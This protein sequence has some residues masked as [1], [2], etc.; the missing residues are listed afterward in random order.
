MPLTTRGHLLCAAAVSLIFLACRS[1]QPGPG[2]QSPVLVRVDG[3]DVTVGEAQA[4]L[5]H[6]PPRLRATYASTSEKQREFMQRL[7]DAELLANKAKALGYD[8][9][10]E[11]IASTK[12][13]MVRRFL[14]ARD[15]ASQ[16]GSEVSPLTVEAFYRDNQAM[17][18]APE[19]ARVT[20]VIVSDGERA[21]EVWRLATASADRHRGD[22]AADIAAFKELV[23]KYSVD[24]ASKSVGG[25]V[26]FVIGP[27]D[28]PLRPLG[29]GAFALKR[30]GD[31]TAPIDIDGRFY[32]L[33][34]R[35]RVPAGPRPLDDGVSDRIKRI[36]ADKRRSAEREEM[37]SALRRGVRVE[38]FDQQLSGLR[39][40]SGPPR[41]IASKAP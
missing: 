14:E 23:T 29:I 25:D 20:Q 4:E 37:L 41:Q 10:P 32:I 28:D 19:R 30:A 24:D 16:A 5:D 36:L 21:T 9:D 22:T 1:R 2:T 7:I 40:D 26:T 13:A 27:P 12:R 11:V 15:A 18:H 34:L 8:K 33:K 17:F 39:F 31:V 38:M 35:E 3:K 6:L